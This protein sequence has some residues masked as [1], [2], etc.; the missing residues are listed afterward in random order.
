MVRTFVT[1][2]FILLLA[3]SGVLFWQW[4][5]YSKDEVLNEKNHP[6]IVEQH[7]RI[8]QNEKTLQVSQTM[9]DLKKGN[10]KLEN[11]L[12]VEIDVDGKKITDDTV[13]LK[14]DEKNITFNYSIP[15]NSKQN[16]MMLHD[17]A[18]QLKNVK[19]NK[20]KVEMTVEGSRTGSWAALAN[21]VGKTN[22]QY[23]DYYVFEGDGPVYPLYY[24]QG[25]LNHE[26][27]DDGPNIYYEKN[28][29]PAL[30]QVASM[31]KEFPTVKESVVILTS[32]HQEEINKN[33]LIINNVNNAQK[34]KNK[35]S[36]LYVNTTFPFENE[37]EK[38][39]QYILENLY[40]NKTDGSSKVNAMVDLIRKELYEPQIKSFIDVALSEDKPLTA[41][42]LDGILSNI[43]GKNTTF[44]QMNS[45]EKNSL[46][47]LYYE[48]TRD[49]VVNGKSLQG[50]FYYQDE[51]LLL[52]FLPIMK[53][54]GYT[55]DL[56][57]DDHI[58]LTKD[59]DSIRLYPNKNVFILNG[60]DYSLASAPL[61][62]K[63][64]EYYLHADWFK[65][66]FGMTITEDDE[67]ISIITN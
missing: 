45:N 53:L 51:K 40:T 50:K 62:I 49:V 28:Y 5:V 64:G 31:L 17:W 18:L 4:S 29:K 22:K 36:D 14:K 19:T 66:I 30:K 38:W 43:K 44:F 9:S 6:S 47:P 48:D 46:I 42:R 58:L 7:I 3:T 15:F 1:S 25:E 33:L 60:I 65:D 2:L 55:Y 34:L 67:K 26:K 41:A 23:V 59:E 27:I 32:K 57:G 12:N 52:P 61:T 16:S 63:N 56:N 24:Q 39:Q 21:Q 35:I 13:S 10:Y 11:H 20:A 54:A 37:Q 8:Q